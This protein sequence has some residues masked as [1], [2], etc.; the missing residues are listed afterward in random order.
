MSLKNNIKL[1]SYVTLGCRAVHKLWVSLCTGLC[2]N[3][4]S[5]QGASS[6][7]L[8]RHLFSLN[9]QFSTG[10]SQQTVDGKIAIPAVFIHLSTE[11]C[12][13]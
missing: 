4:G 1:N 13:S 10:N 9:T 11:M 12:V 3:L 5:P 8:F 7:S 6:L 2:F